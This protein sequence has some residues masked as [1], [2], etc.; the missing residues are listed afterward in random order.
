MKKANHSCDVKSCFLCKGCVTEWLP[1]VALNRRN[2]LFKKGELLFE[3]GEEV[4]GIYFL[5]KGRAKVHKQWGSDKELIM[6]FAMAGDIIGHRGFGAGSRFPVSAT[7]LEPTTICFVDI[8][9]FLSTLKMNPAL[10]FKLMMFYAQELH[11]TEQRMRDLVHMDMKGRLA[12]S[13][14]LLQKQ[15][16][17]DKAGNIDMIITRQDLASFAGA[18]YETVFRIMNELVHDKLVEARDKN[19]KILNEE[20]LRAFT[21]S[22]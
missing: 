5:Y 10:T 14:L 19:I 21:A 13:L 6:R 18:S 1:L 16:G 4:T 17:A 15:F 12:D 9:F 22:A 11:N 7:A 20:G 8:D 2:L 3:E